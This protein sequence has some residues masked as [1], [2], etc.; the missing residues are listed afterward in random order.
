M[1]ATDSLAQ[2]RNIGIVAHIDAGKTTTTERIL[3]YSGRIHRLGEVDD[4]TATMDWMVQEKERGIT[5]TS[6]VTTTSWQDARINIIDTPGHVDFTVEVE[7][8]LRVLDGAVVVLCAV[9]AV[10]PQ[11][12]T[13]WRQADRYRVPR[14]AYI[15]KMDRMGADYFRVLR[16][17][18]DRL[19]AHP[20][21]IQIPIGAEEKFTGVID[22]VEQKAY[23]YADDLGLSFEVREIPAEYQTQAQEYRQLLLENIV[24]LEEESLIKYLEGV[25]LTTQEIRALIRKGTLEGKFVPVLAGSSYRNKGIQP[26]LDAIVSYLPSPLDIPPVRG[27]NPKNKEIEERPADTAASLSSLAF[28]IMSDPFVGK[29]TFIRVYSGIMKTGTYVLNAT[30]VERE[31]IGRLI[32]LHAN[33]REDIEEIAAGDLG[34]IVGLRLTTTGDTLADIEAPILLEAIRFPT[35]VI[36]VAIEPK[37]KADQDK[38]DLSLAKLSEEDPSFKV[39]VDEETGQTVISGMGELHLEIIVDRLLREFKVEANVGK[40]QVSYRETITRLAKAEGKYIKQTGGRGQ[41]GHVVLMVEP[42]ERGSGFVFEN[43]IISGAV[44]REYVPSVEAGA[45]DSAEGGVLVGFPMI[46]IK[47]TLVDGSFHPVDSSDIAF[48]IAGSKGLREAVRKAG[49]VILEPIMKTEIIIP[50]EYLGDVLGGITARRGHIEGMEQ[51]GNTH[52]IQAKAPLVEMFGYATDL[53]SLTQGRGT[54]T[55]E[56]F[57]Y[58]PAPK[59]ISDPL[60]EAFGLR[61]RDSDYI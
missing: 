21:P 32:R 50:E 31:R 4:G 44:P 35:P 1:N 13:V 40:P 49:P 58:E 12:E 15:N 20:I 26:L 27:I 28:K 29:L 2:I 5:I 33:K 56:F 45:R 24:D 57:R 17:M 43:K 42:L 6:A 23:V 59:Q 11:S 36:S 37:S 9:A 7:R 14:I 3:F 10:Q 30:K 41:Y 38:L 16:M 39:R 25:E 34:A 53:R 61:G 52:I 54:H 60:V 8:S 51:T 46:D 47:V 48:R 22:L 18:K 19:G 55:M